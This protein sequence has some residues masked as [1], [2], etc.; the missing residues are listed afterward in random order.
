MNT[1]YRFEFLVVATTGRDQLKHE[2]EQAKRDANSKN[3]RNQG[4]K[5]IH[6]SATTPCNQTRI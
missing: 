2:Q 4:S 1:G 5:S 3:C 6:I